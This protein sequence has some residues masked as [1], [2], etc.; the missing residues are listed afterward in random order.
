MRPLHAVSL[1]LAAALGGCGT[2]HAVHNAT[3]AAVARVG[4]V[5]SDIYERAETLGG[6]AYDAAR[7]AASPPVLDSVGDPTSLAGETFRTMPQ[8]AMVTQTAGAPNSLWRPGARTF[9]NDQRAQTVG[10]ILTVDIAIEDSAAVTN[11]SSRARSGETAVGVTNFLGLENLPGQFLPGDFDP[12]AL[13][14]GNSTSTAR[15]TG[16]VNR[17]EA[18]QMTIAAV[19]VDILPN[20]NLVIAGRQQVMINAELRELTV[21]G[22]IRPE[23]IAANNTIRHDQIAEARIAYGGRGQI[24]AVQRPRLGQRVADAISPW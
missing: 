7:R 13:I 16:S 10:D 22:V 4:D 20:G 11:T 23:D 3:D 2:V 1:V 5:G 9:F 15:G 18:I 24:S 19:I 6:A 21:S 8:P 12:N 17:Q 14:G